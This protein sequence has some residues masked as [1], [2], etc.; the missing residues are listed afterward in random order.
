M[1]NKTA[2]IS[3]VKSG[4][5]LLDKPQNFTSNDMVAIARRVL[6]TK[7][8][9]HSGTLDPMATGLLILLVERQATRL[10]NQF[11]Q[12]DKVYQATLK[13]GIDTDTWDAQGT[14]LNSAPI[15]SISIADIE[16]TAQTLTGTVRQQIP[17]FSAK[18]INGQK[19]YD[20]ARNGQPVSDRY[21]EIKIF[22]WQDFIW[23][24]KDQLSFTL[25]CSC[26]TY[27]RSVARMLAQTLGTT[28]HLTQLRRLSIGPFHVQNSFD[29]SK[30][31]TVSHAEIVQW[32][33]EPQ[34]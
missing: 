1:D 27:V 22:S 6:R 29:G 34:L 12:L 18:K 20:L 8:I 19:M 28:G 2:S 10:Q 16:Q 33:Q 13:L 21:N 9:G 32:L 30:L 26:G 24:G 5:L 14:P 4:L 11:L 15:P 3:S 23:D 7:C 17:P 25:H 31:K